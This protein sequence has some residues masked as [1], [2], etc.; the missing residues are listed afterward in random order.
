[1]CPEAQCGQEFIYCIDRNLVFLFTSVHRDFFFAAS[2][3]TVLAGCQKCILRVHRIILGKNTF[4]WKINMLF[5]QF[6]TLGHFFANIPSFWLNRQNCIPSVEMH[7]EEISFK[8]VFLVTLGHG[9][10][11]FRLLWKN[12]WQGCQNPFY[13]SKGTFWGTICCSGKIRIF[14]IIFDSCVNFFRPF[15][16]FFWRVCQNSL[17]CVQMH[18]RKKKFWKCFSHFRKMSAKFSCVRKKIFDRVSRRQSTCPKWWLKFKVCLKKFSFPSLSYI[19]KTIFCP[20]KKNSQSVTNAIYVFLGTVCWKILFQ[21]ILFFYHFWTFRD[22]IP[23]FRRKFF[24]TT[25][26]IDFLAVQNNILRKLFFGKNLFFLYL[27]G[28]KKLSAICRIVK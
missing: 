14:S 19:E 9:A 10:R 8:K 24:E 27:Q 26:R 16:E 2:G 4:C 23:A 20:L 11:R 17:L 25:V 21:K 15:L 3:K 28:A 6:R 12:F 7:F 1:M 18:F 5:H 13:V 22:N